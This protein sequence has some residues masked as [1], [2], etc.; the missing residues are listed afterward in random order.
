M[1]EEKNNVAKKNIIW[2]LVFSFVNALQTVVL[3][4]F[5]KR[6]VNE[7]SAGIFGY[8]FSVAVL[9]MYI[10]NYGI[11]NYQVSDT[12]E[13]YS[14]AEYC[15]FRV[16]SCVCMLIALVVALIYLKLPAEKMWAVFLLSLERLAESVEDVFHGRYQQKGH[17]YRAGKQGTV[18]LIVSDVLFA[19]ILLISKNMLWACIGYTGISIIIVAFYASVTVKDYGGFGIS[20][21][22]GAMKAIGAA[23]FPLF[24]GYFFSTYLTNSPK[25][26]IEKYSG[27]APDIFSDVTQAYFNMIFMPV[28]MINLLSTV[29]FR[30][31]IVT[32][33]KEYNSGHY[34][35]YKK[36]VNKQY[37]W[38]LVIS[39]ISLP[40]CFFLGIPA[41]S[42]FYGSDLSV[43]KM[44]FMILM[45]GGI[46]SAY[47]SFLNVCIITIRKQKYYLIATLAL[48]I[49]LIVIS[50]FLP[51]TYGLDGISL[52]YLFVMIIQM[53]LYYLIHTISV[54]REEKKTTIRE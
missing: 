40:V 37:L 5:V 50:N 20:M 41:L 53:I 47:S 26:I 43:Y 27:I 42:L 3:L 2:N 52:L 8:A 35:K 48:I 51:Y 17:L 1:F 30:P 36:L 19:L 14:F 21:K 18:R 38:I 54:L 4:F 15:G 31:H 10:G 23:C 45:L 44:D 46:F 25:Y 22:M 16:I 34:D 13:K 39:V 33:A 24:C 29:I 12:D 6:F 32:M 11:R 49:M 28:L 9:L 7:N